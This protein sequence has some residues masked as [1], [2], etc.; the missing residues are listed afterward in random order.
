MILL[1]APYS[2]CYSSAEVSLKCDLPD[3][4]ISPGNLN[5][6]LHAYTVNYACIY[7]LAYECGHVPAVNIGMLPLIASL[8]HF[9]ETGSHH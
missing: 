8:S 7:V 1:P 6:G 5:S 2:P 9:F 4:Y 3:S